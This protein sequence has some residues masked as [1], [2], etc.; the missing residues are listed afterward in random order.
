MKKKPHEKCYDISCF[1][2]GYEIN[3]ILLMSL[4]QMNHFK[5]NVEPNLGLK[6]LGGTF[7]EL[8]APAAVLEVSMRR[9]CNEAS[10]ESGI[11]RLARVSGGRMPRDDR[12]QRPG[13]PLSSFDRG[14][15][16]PSRF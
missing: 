3:F 15:L 11:E 8:S 10:M 13:E 2:L 4:A 12:L 1:Y 14:L 5:C 9:N 7:S 16:R 6:Y